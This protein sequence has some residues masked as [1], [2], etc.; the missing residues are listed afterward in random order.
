MIEIWSQAG[1]LPVLHWVWA[2]SEVLMCPVRPLR[3]HHHVLVHRVLHLH[4]R[5]VHELRLI[6]ELPVLPA[7]THSLAHH[8]LLLKLDGQKGLDSAAEKRI[9]SS[10]QVR[11]CA[12]IH[13]R[14]VIVFLLVHLFID[15][16]LLGYTQ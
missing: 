13:P 8:P 5:R 7:I 16:I 9:V 6:L 4:H 1:L 10:R 14:N 12:S 3:W 15:D 11:G 2:L